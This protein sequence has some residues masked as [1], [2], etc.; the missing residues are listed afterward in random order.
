MPRNR[1]NQPGPFTEIGM[2]PV[3]TSSSPSSFTTK[4]VAPRTRAPDAAPRGEVLPTTPRA[5]KA[6]PRQKMVG[7]SASRGMMSYKEG[8]LVKG[9][10]KKK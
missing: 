7:P 5:A 4:P 3:R 2:G 6:K 10:K 9:K 1:Q 8:G